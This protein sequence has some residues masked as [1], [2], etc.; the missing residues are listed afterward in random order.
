MSKKPNKESKKPLEPFSVGDFFPDNKEPKKGR[1]KLLFINDD[2]D[3]AL[4]FTRYYGLLGYD[5]DWSMTPEPNGELAIFN[6][7]DLIFVPNN[8]VQVIINVR[9][10]SLGCKKPKKIFNLNLADVDSEE[11]EGVLLPYVDGYFTKIEDIVS[12][13]IHL[14]DRVSDKQRTVAMLMMYVKTNPEFEPIYGRTVKTIN[15]IQ[16]KADYYKKLDDDRPSQCDD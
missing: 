10:N 3:I 8:K 15:E 16:K 4:L 1:C 12:K 14:F 11:D 13:N 2:K 9:I 5:T 6:W 7:A